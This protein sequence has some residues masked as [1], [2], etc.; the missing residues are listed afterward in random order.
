MKNPKLLL[1]AI[2]LICFGLLGAALYLQFVEYMQPCPWCI[3]Q[4]Y[5][6]TAIALIC[7]V[8]AF[9]PAKTHR[10][11]AGLGLLAA[12]G[13]IGSASWH[14]WVKAHPAVSCGLDPVETSLNKFPTAKLLPFLFRPEGE[15]GTEY[16]PLFGLS[17]PQWSLLWFVVFAVVLG[18]LALRRQRR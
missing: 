5:L 3:I 15:C 4:R 13:G 17:I 16:A 8:S 11:G 14:L 18:M 7:L 10:G 12:L 6:F 2:A 1:I 9:L